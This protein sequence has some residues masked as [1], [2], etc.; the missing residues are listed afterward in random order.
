MSFLLPNTVA[1]YSAVGFGIVFG[2]L[3]HRGSLANFNT[4]VEQLRLRDFTILKVMLT[5]IIIG[6][7]GV[8]FIVN[9]AGGHYHIK[10]A[11]LLAVGLGAAIFGIGMAIY[12]YCPGTAICAIGTGSL[13]ALVGLIG[14]IAGAVL[15]ALSFDWVQANIIPV[16][17]LG[18]VRL[19]DLTQIPDLVWFGIMAVAAVVLFVVFELL[20]VRRQR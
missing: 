19:P 14:M 3:L 13:H 17:A 2:I 1:L 15:F 12:G 16:E 4:I 11:N 9:Y 6:G 10:A 8:Y 5:A 7:I 18:K 20:P